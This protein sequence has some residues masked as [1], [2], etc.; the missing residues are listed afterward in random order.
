MAAPV[1]ASVGLQ[2]SNE[3]NL[4]NVGAMRVMMVARSCRQS[5]AQQGPFLGSCLL[6]LSISDIQCVPANIIISYMLLGIEEIGVRGGGEGKGRGG[7]V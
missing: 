7:G 3:P 5:N 2:T 1:V 6:L 4:R